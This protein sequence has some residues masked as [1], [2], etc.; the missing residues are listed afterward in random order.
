[1]SKILINPQTRYEKISSNGSYPK[2][3]ER[4]QNSCHFSEFF[5]LETVNQK[6]KYTKSSLNSSVIII[7]IICKTLPN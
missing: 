7:I 1:M 6:G 2:S 4:N 5:W 3:I